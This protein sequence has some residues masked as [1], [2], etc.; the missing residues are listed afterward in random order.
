MDH[1]KYDTTCAIE[2]V[3]TDLRTER[4]FLL[5]KLV[6]RPDKPKPDKVPCDARGREIDGTD[7][8]HWRTLDDVATALSASAARAH[9]IGVALG[10]GLVGVDLDNVHDPQSGALTAAAAAI[11][12]TLNSY[13][14]V[15]PSGTGV[16]IL[17][18]GALPDGVKHKAAL[19]DGGTVEV[20]DGKRFFTLSGKRVPGAPAVVAE[21]TDA[22][23]TVC[24]RWGLLKCPTPTPS[25][26]VAS[27]RAAQSIAEIA[28]N[29]DLDALL[30]DRSLR[31]DR[32]FAALWTGDTSGYPS[33][34]EADHALC[35]RL[36]QLVGG[37]VQRA[38]RLFRQSGLYRA[39]WQERRGDRTYG[40]RTLAA[41]LECYRT[42]LTQPAL[43]QSPGSI[44]QN[45]HIAVTA[46]ATADIAAADDESPPWHPRRLVSDDEIKQ[47]ACSGWLKAYIAYGQRR[48]DAP[49]TF[50]EAAGLVVLSAVIGRRAVLHLGVGDIYPNVW[51]LILA[52]SSLYRKSTA[53]DL[54]R[55][56]IEAVDAECLAPDD[57]TPQRFVA[58]LA[59]HDGQP[60]VLVRDE[61]SGFYEG[62]TR[63]D[64]QT[65]LKETLCM[66]Y[67]GRPFRREKM[68]PR[69]RRDVDEI[70]DDGAW[71][72]AARQPFLSILAGSTPSRFYDIARP[73]D[74]TSGFLA[75][76]AFEL[77]PDGSHLTRPIRPL[78]DDTLHLRA[79]LLERLHTLRHAPLRV[80]IG[81]DVTERLN[82]YISAL[83]AEAR[84]APNGELVGVVAAR[85]PWW[86]VRAAMLL[87]S[88]DASATGSAPV[89]LPHVYQALLI[90][91]RWRHA[92]LRV[93]GD[94]APSH[95]ERTATRVVDLVRRKPTGIARRDVM[96]ALRI[97]RR[98]MDDVQATLAERG[99]IVV[100]AH[101]ARGG[102][103]GQSI[104]FYL[105]ASASAGLSREAS[106]L[107]AVS[108]TPLHTPP[109]TNV[110]DSTD[111]TAP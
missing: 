30:V 31:T 80:M 41:A 24:A 56:L 109:V 62:L 107:P 85:A 28:N 11:V 35:M 98:L 77:P 106:P 44:G 6:R 65:G 73:G 8:V 100:R 90:T 99:E 93:L 64:F 87:A 108:D 16:H 89:A 7:L 63:L 4:R 29:G 27:D 52:P 17:L 58:V 68:K 71:C 74:V 51:V 20:Y 78:D 50:H 45:A 26:H 61:F 111:S 18:R 46:A 84:Q 81:P 14:E 23:A 40:E 60:L 42:R 96:R 5:Y 75:R 86:A 91:E 92:A 94:I 66:A 83:E 43:A 48:T 34:S 22:L 54:A 88:A 38:D 103:G 76:F 37:D 110:T 70:G 33:P 67:D 47:A 13:T 36:L 39:K 25:A 57:F 82:Q 15:S 79:Q 32:H 95:F 12:A 104:W 72:F 101:A 55:D 2:E 59:E 3:P 10:D 97:S 105:P 69:R 21:R 9:G 1:V 102:P 53:L 19:P 49:V